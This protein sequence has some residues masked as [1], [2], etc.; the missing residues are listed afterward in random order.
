VEPA[1]L[2]RPILTGPHLEN[3]QAIAESLRQAKGVLVVRTLEEMEQAAG[4]LLQD[5][6]G[7]RDLGARAMAVFRENQGA[8]KR[9]ADLIM[10]RWGKVLS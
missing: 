5:P 8:V 1:S 3:F 2:G 10:L 9:T 6:T 7:A 4:R